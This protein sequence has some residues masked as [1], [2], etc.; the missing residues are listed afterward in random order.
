MQIHEVIRDA[1][2]A[3]VFGPDGAIEALVAAKKAGKIR[4]IGFTGHKSPAIHLKML[5]AAAAHRFTF[6]TVQMPLNVMDAHYD[7]FERRVLPVA[8]KSG[9]AV[10]AMKPLGS[11]MFLRSEPL[12][13]RQ[14]SPTDCLRYAMGSSASV[15]ITGCESM[16][17]LAQAL[18]AAYGSQ[19][20]TARI[21]RWFSR[22]RPRPP[23]K[24][25]W[26][27]Y[28]TSGTFDGTARNP[29]WLEGATL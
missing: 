3:R 17:D 21:A 15:V 11:G 18:D 10:L 13:K 20:M 16:R 5:E 4:F 19:A 22:A 7:S 28:K 9:V 23:A 14:V 12:A 2:P 8:D 27:K 24:G 26:E 6:D 1:D 29:H 25:E